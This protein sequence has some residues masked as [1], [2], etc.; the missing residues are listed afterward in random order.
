MGDVNNW[1][2]VVYYCYFPTLPG[3]LLTVHY[4]LAKEEPGPRRYA[5]F[6]APTVPIIWQLCAV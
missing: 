2:C 3:R 5:D 4:L 1:Q 6:Y